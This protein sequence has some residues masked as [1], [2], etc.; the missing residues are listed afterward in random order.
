MEQCESA[1]ALLESVRE[2]E[3]QFEQL[4]RALEEERRRVGLPATSPSTLGRPLPHTQV[5][6]QRTQIFPSWVI[7]TPLRL[8]LY[9]SLFPPS[10]PWREFM[11][12]LSLDIHPS[13]THPLSPWSHLLPSSAQ[14]G[15][16]CAS[17]LKLF[18]LDLSLWTLITYIWLVNSHLQIY[19][20]M[21]SK[22][23]SM[24]TVSLTG[25][26]LTHIHFSFS[27]AV[28]FQSFS[29]PFTALCMCCIVL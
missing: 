22:P 10:N 11:H 17:F 8:W 13:I 19:H 28:E 18:F 7:S 16:F 3:V 14:Q 23:I 6:P 4:T 5:T 25:R 21:P 27:P 20:Y 2:Q 12:R 9:G 26:T 24:P 1:A 29:Y 15:R